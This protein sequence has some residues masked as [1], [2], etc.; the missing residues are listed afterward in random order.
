MLRTE[1]Q[2]LQGSQSW[3]RP[4]P[5]EACTMRFEAARLMSRLKAL[6]H[7]HR[8]EE[9]CLEERRTLAQV[10]MVLLLLVFWV[11]A[12]VAQ[13]KL[14]VLSGAGARRW[15]WWSW[16]AAALISGLPSVLTLLL[17]VYVYVLG[18]ASNVVQLAGEGSGLHY[19]KVWFNVWPL[20][21]LTN[22][23]ALLVALVVLVRPCHSRQHRLAL[24]GRFAGVAA[25]LISNYLVFALYPTA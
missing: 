10:A 15:R 3:R 11:A 13:L 7:L 6:P 16:P 14:V 19:W 18:G 8:R 5:S 17:F 2:T 9:G 23:P 21:V 12:L 25:L 20:L 1:A 22:P 4:A 24:V